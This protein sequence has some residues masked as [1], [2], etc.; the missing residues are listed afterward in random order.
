[1][2]RDEGSEGHFIHFTTFRA[3]KTRKER[4]AP[5]SSDHVTFRSRQAGD[6]IIR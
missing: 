4:R 2:S 3:G 6:M 1:M 5:K